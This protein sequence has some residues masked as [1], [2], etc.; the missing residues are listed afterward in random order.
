[1]VRKNDDEVELDEHDMQQISLLAIDEIDENDCIDF[2]EEV[3]DHGTQL[4]EIAELEH[5]LMVDEIDSQMLLIIDDDEVVE[6]EVIT[7][8]ESDTNE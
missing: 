1:M 6:D 5:E 4:L 8:E 3:D 7:L 2:D